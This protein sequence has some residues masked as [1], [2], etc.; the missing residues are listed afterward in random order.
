MMSNNKKERVVIAPE[1]EDVKSPD[2]KYVYATGVF[3]GIVPNDA[4]II[5]FLDRLEPSTTNEPRPGTSKVKKIIRELQVE[6]H[7]T[8]HQFKSIAIWMNNHIKQYEDR[9]GEI[10]MKPKKDTAPDKLVT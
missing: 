3:G 6:V 2:Y 8:P 4:R 10:T 1:F 9:F 7:T 5:F